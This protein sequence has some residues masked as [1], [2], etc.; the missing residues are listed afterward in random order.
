FCGRIL[1]TEK[2]P[3]L[4]GFLQVIPWTRTHAFLLAP[5]RP[6]RPFPRRSR[7]SAKHHC[8]PRRMP[9][10]QGWNE[11]GLQKNAPVPLQPFFQ[12]TLGPRDKHGD[13]SESLLLV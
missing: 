7:A 4:Q 12:K 2:S 9:R 1:C 5:S 11:E 13:D 3:D 6:Q 10:A 8:R